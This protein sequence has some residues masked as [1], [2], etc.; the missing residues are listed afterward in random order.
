MELNDLSMIQMK[1]TEDANFLVK[2]I[3]MLINLGGFALT[4]AFV[5]YFFEIGRQLA[6]Q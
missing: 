2:L 6:T 4:I 3:C 5:G 1:S